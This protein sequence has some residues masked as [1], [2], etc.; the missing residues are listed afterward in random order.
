[1]QSNKLT[2]LIMDDSEIIQE[3][4]KE[5]LCKIDGVECVGKVTN[6]G[7]GLDIVSS[8]KPGLVVLDIRLADR[9]G[10][11]IIKKIKH[12]SPHTIVV[13]LTN[14]TFSAYRIHCMSLGADYFLDKSLEFSKV[15]D[16]A[17]YMLTPE[18]RKGPGRR[19]GYSDSKDMVDSGK[20]YKPGVRTR[21]MVHKDL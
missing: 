21:Q 10:M 12:F 15:R 9:V 3:R 5:I 8:C 18:Y 7:E 13:V 16:I 17:E 1:M 11:D 4:L 14:Y 19:Y 6:S 20:R 2:I